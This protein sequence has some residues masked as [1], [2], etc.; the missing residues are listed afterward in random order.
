MDIRDVGPIQRRKFHTLTAKYHGS[1]DLL[2]VNN[3]VRSSI[4]RS[5]VKGVLEKRNLKGMLC[6]K[7]NART[8]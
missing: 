7:N 6:W 2:L 8:I 3:L 1:S 5:D 4:C